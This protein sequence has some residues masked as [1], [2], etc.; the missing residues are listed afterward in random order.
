MKQIVS[1]KTQKINERY[2][3]ERKIM[4]SEMKIYGTRFNGE[5]VIEDCGKSYIYNENTNDLHEAN[6]LELG[7]YQ[8]KM[9]EVRDYNIDNW[10]AWN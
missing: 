10:M 1:F 6:N 5:Y 4:M 8:A 2:I 7:F 3:K 9:Y